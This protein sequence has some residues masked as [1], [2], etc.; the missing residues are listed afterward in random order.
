M[1]KILA[2]LAALAACLATAAAFATTTY[3]SRTITLLV[4]FGAGLS[5]D[6]IA[7]YMAEEVGK[8]VG[9]PMIV[10]NRAGANGSLGTTLAARAAPDGY[11]LVFASNGTHAGNVA[12]VRK[13]SYDA[14]K[15]FTPIGAI[16]AAPWA[17]AVR[18]DMPV[19][20]MAEFLRY[21]TAHKAGVTV[22]H[23]SASSM[24]CMALLETKG[25][26]DVTDVPYK[27][28]QPAMLDLQASRLDAAFLPLGVAITAHKAGNIRVLA[29]SAAKR[30]DLAP[31][32]PTL[33]EFLPGYEL[34]SWIGIMAPAGTPPEAVKKLHGAMAQVLA[35]P[36][37]REKLAGFGHDV[38]AL[39]PA[40]FGR[41]VSSDIVRW[42][43]LVQDANLEQR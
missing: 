30:S 43:Q 23:G 12:L 18:P 34:V 11:T 7:R 37:T 21:A 29:I 25:G 6:A 28:L 20:D 39:D 27:S 1:K 31:E 42:K 32:I 15:D 35:R 9:Q 10:E 14:V 40:Q 8:I 4:P 16:S 3:P 19:K 2:T 13:L 22:A 17:L 24:A 41:L 38:L 33:A 36:A 5:T 26:I